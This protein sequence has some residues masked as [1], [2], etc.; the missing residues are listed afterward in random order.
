MVIHL[1]VIMHDSKP[2]YVF[3]TLPLCVGCEILFS[4]EYTVYVCVCVLNAAV[5]IV[6]IELAVCPQYFW[7]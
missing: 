4:N 6:K 7:S 1:R 2:D 5:P 3:L